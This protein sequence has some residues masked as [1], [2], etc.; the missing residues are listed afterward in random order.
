MVFLETGGRTVIGAYIDAD[1]LAPIPRA[2][3]T[4]VEQGVIGNGQRLGD[5]IKSDVNDNDKRFHGW[6][7]SE[8]G[9]GTWWNA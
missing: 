9:M 2:N 7:Q 1:I 5:V 8:S 6:G 4:D 3:K